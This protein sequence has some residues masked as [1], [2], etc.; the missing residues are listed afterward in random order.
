MS[1]VKKKET[2][3]NLGQCA[4]NTTGMSP[5]TGTMP[6]F[7]FALTILFCVDMVTRFLC[8]AD[9]CGSGAF[10]GFR[11]A[12]FRNYDFAFSL[13]VPAI[14]IYGIY[15]VVII[16]LVRFMVRNWTL[17]STS[18]NFAW[19]LVCVGAAANIIDRI[20][21]GYVRDF[22]QFGTG[23]FNLGDVWIVLGIIYI[24]LHSLRDNNAH[25]S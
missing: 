19:A 6:V 13:K 24:C 18:I 8:F 5:R 17:H 23:Y 9:A 7:L 15:A 22:I 3:L 4:N 12:E 16:A 2:G 25:I 1:V 21:F 20:Y 10:L 14:F 11:V